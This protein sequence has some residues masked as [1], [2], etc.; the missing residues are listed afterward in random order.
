MIRAAAILLAAAAL[1]APPAMAQDATPAD[2]E[3]TDRVTVTGQRLGPRTL[4][5]QTR[6]FVTEIARPANFKSGIARWHMRL[7]VGVQNIDPEPA[8]YIVDRI[9]EV[10]AEVGLRPGR[11]GCRPQIMI[12]FAPD[13]Q[14]FAARWVDAQP[15]NFRPWGGVGGTNP[16]LAALDAFQE[17]DAPVRWWHVTL[18]V[19]EGGAPAVKL[20]N[21]LVPSAF[22]DA[23]AIKGGNSHITRLVRD[24]MK[25]ANIVVDGP[26]AAQVGIAQLADYLAMIALVQIDPAADPSAYDSIL[27]LFSAGAAAPPGLTEWDRAYIRAVYDF[28]QYSLPHMQADLVAREM[29]RDRRNA[30]R[31]DADD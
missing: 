27:N 15:Q 18:P 31:E 30:E 4:E 13:G 26:E 17:S 5:E 10:A 6:D 8:Q 24:E 16:G 3:I 1:A 23:P 2:G 29:I 21:T 28:R 7:C 12:A 20:P 22:G 14:D 11:P 19:T 9:S 25:A